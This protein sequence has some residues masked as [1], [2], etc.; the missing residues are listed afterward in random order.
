MAGVTKL[1]AFSCD[2]SI[3]LYTVIIPNKSN[4]MG[5]FINSVNSHSH[6]FILGVRA[7]GDAA[8]PL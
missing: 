5:I 3:H 1:A 2:K 8:A 7:D 6:A 4:L